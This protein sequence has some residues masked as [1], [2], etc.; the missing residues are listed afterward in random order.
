M[1]VSHHLTPSPQLRT[2]NASSLSK[3]HTAKGHY[4]E[5][6]FAH[7]RRL[8]LKEKVVES[9]AQQLGAGVRRL[10]NELFKSAMRAQRRDAAQG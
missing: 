10:F 1:R 8:R 9:G 7:L 3:L 5:E 6:A 4:H 2:N